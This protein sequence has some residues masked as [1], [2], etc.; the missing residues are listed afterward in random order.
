MFFLLAAAI[1]LAIGLLLGGSMAGFARLRF[2]WPLFVV[3]ALVMKNVAFTSFL[4]HM[5]WIPF[6]YLLSLIGLL[7]WTLY[8]AGRLPALWLVSAGV[9]MN[10]MVVISNGGHM[11]V[12]MSLVVKGSPALQA[13]MAGG[14]NGQYIVADAG[15]HLLWL[16]DWLEM[17]GPIHRFFPQAYSPGDYLIALGLVLLPMLLCRPPALSRAWVRAS[18]FAGRRS[19]RPQV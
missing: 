16:G 15:T 2:R 11:P 4:S 1:G 9:A 6:V 3:A 17:P 7:G 14:S 13:A 12:P 19:P 10:L 5:P 8:H 18:Q